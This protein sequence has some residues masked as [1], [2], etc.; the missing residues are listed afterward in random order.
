MTL[1]MLILVAKINDNLVKIACYIENVKTTR[2]LKV[3]NKRRNDIQAL[4]HD[5]IL[6]HLSL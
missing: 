1:F 3:N 4:P 5:I 6:C 2:E